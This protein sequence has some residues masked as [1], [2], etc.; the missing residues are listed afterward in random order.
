MRTIK[1]RGKTEN[2]EWFYGNFLF[3]NCNPQIVSF[4]GLFRWNVNKETIGQFTGLNDKNGIEI[5]EGDIF[6]YNQ[7][8]GYLLNDFTAIVQ[9]DES[10]ACLGYVE[11]EST[12]KFITPFCRHDELEKDIFL[13]IDV[14]GNIHDNPELLNIKK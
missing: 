5:Y 6:R 12:T 11:I 1:F 8:K 7:H 13:H 10:R 3:L 2:G 4:A 14:I 9:Y